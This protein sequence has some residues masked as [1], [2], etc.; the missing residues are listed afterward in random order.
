[1]PKS[2]VITALRLGTASAKALD[3][4]I[5]R[6]VKAARAE[7][8][9]AGV[10][11]IVARSSHELVHEAIVAYCQMKLGETARYEQFKE[12]WEYQ[13]ENLR[14]SNKKLEAQLAEE[15]KGV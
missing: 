12:S 1:M 6:N 5:D 9:R 13:V 14:K 10:S 15:E 3:S 4:E 7:M 2:S 8:I 11:A